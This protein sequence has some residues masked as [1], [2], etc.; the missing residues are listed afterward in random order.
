M[1][2]FLNSNNKITPN[3]WYSTILVDQCLVQPS[4]EKILHGA[5]VGKKIKRNTVRQYALNERHWNT[6][7]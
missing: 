6:Q 7:H 3:E 2:L 4:S 1:A 5:Q